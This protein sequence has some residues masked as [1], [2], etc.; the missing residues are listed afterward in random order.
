MGEKHPS[1]SQIRE[2]VIGAQAGEMDAWKGLYE[3]FYPRMIRFLGQQTENPQ[4]AEDFAQDAFITAVTKIGQYKERPGSDFGGWILRIARTTFIDHCRAKTR[5]TNYIKSLESSFDKMAPA[6]FDENFFLIKALRDLYPE[7][8]PA[9]QEIA[10]LRFTKELSPTEAAFRLGK[11]END[12][13]VLTF[14]AKKRLIKL[15]WE[16]IKGNESDY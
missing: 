4:D 14:K 7:L 3:E 1:S 9:E 8:T 12:V 11:S 16:K 15:F 2:L 5:N 13:K 6:D 10:E